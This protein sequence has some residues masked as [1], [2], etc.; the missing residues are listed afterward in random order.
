[1]IADNTIIFEDWEYT[2]KIERHLRLTGLR[3]SPVEYVYSL[4]YKKIDDLFYK[5]TKLGGFG[6]GVFELILKEKMLICI[7][8][9]GY[10]LKKEKRDLTTDNLMIYNFHEMNIVSY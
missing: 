2:Y 3:F 1:M 7:M 5:E 10:V 4:K 9:R 6:K 8:I